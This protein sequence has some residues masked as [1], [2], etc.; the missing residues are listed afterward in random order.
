MRRFS[1]SFLLACL[2][3]LTSSVNF[4]LADNISQNASELEHLASRSLLLDIVSLANKRLI[5][6]GAHGNILTSDDAIHWQQSR[7]P[8][9]STLTGIYFINNK[10]GWVV[11]H[12]ASI[13]H[14]NDAGVTWQVQQY[15]PQKEK[16]LLDIIFKNE[17][18]GIAVGAYGMFYRTHDGGKTWQSEF[19]QEFLTAD[20]VDYIAELK[21]EDEV[22]YLDEIS[23]ILPHFN[24][25]IQKGESLYLVG[26]IGLIAKSDDF[27]VHWQ[28]FGEIYQGSFF[29]IVRTQQDNLIVAG[30]R[31]NVF[32]RLKNSSSWSSVATHTSA[33]LNS[34]ILTDD[35]R[36]I[37][38]GNNGV[39]LV[40]DNDGK[41]YQL[42]VQSDGKA[43][44]AGVWFNHQVVAV[45]DV[46]IK[47]IKVK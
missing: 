31:G 16:P 18:Q 28:K 12:D 10:Q 45:S 30:L 9:Q 40:S 37:V 3:S 5:A 33:L 26:E 41:S 23:S 25:I 34:I 46:G 44:I 4:V 19:H 17:L 39:M 7:V 2:L 11:G 14:T 1:Y 21:A 8:I 36:I 22:A 15:L 24:R 35:D 29:D 20:D 43:L 47:I 38:L 6:V 27:G 32:R 13:L 42:E